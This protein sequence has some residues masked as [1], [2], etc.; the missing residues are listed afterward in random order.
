MRSWEP[1]G[2]P[3]DRLEIFRRRI[4]LIHRIEELLLYACLE[5][6]SDELEKELEKLIDKYG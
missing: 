3:K 4:S 5:I 2:L 6:N 1:D